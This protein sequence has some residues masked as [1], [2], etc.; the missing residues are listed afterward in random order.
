MERFI[1][2]VDGVVTM[3]SGLIGLVFPSMLLWLF[4]VG[5]FPVLALEMTRWAAMFLFMFGYLQWRCPSYGLEG[6]KLFHRGAFMADVIFPYVFFSLMHRGGTFS[7]TAFVIIVY[8]F[9]LMWHRW[10]VVRAP[11]ILLNRPL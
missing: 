11:D 3:F 5:P 10:K 2:K 7:F 1:F 9:W 8:H 6:I 4:A